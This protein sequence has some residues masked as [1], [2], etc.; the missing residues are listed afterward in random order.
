MCIQL[1]NALK[2]VGAKHGWM[3]VY[4]EYK[5]IRMTESVYQFGIILPVLNQRQ[6]SSQRDI[7]FP[8]LGISDL[9]ISN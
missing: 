3:V 4:R 1:T 7:K 5:S 8:S 9:H 6:I 2:M